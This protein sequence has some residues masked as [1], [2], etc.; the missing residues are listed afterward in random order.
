MH[1]HRVSIRRV[2]AKTLLLLLLVLVTAA[3][4][5]AAGCKA[6]S[7]PSTAVPVPKTAITSSSG[8][9]LTVHVSDTRPRIGQNVEIEVVLQNMSNTKVVLRD[10][11]GTTTFEVNNEA[12]ETVWGI[13]VWRPGT[14]LTV[15]VT[16]GWQ[17][18]VDQIWIVKTDP[19]FHQEVGPGKY[20]IT[21]SDSFWDPGLGETVPLSIEPVELVVSK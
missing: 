13:A 19:S 20:Y 11:G 18:V 21:V 4:M 3:S 14:T 7:T 5:M 17:Y 1:M 8:F 2:R 9:R 16:P 6:R 10:M 12:G 15:P